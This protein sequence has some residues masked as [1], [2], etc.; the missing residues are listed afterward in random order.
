MI[1]CSYFGRQRERKGL[2]MEVRMVVRM[3]RQTWLVFQN[4]HQG[5]R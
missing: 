4:C 1:L 3:S 2:R 5:G